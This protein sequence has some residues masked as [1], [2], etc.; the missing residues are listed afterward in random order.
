MQDSKSN[1]AFSSFL[2]FQAK[3]IL[4]KGTLKSIFIDKLNKI[5]VTQVYPGSN[6]FKWMSNLNA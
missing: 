1:E 3:I 4:E 2:H 5:Y 6:V